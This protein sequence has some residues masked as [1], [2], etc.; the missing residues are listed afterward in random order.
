MDPLK[1]EERGLADYYETLGVAKGASGDEIKKAYRKLAL[2][3]HPD[4]NKQ[5]PNAEEKFK[6]ISEAYAVLSDP[7][8]KKQYDAFGDQGFHQRYSS[9]DIFRGADSIFQEFDLG[10]DSFF[11]KIFGNQFHGG[12][13]R[14][15]FRPDAQ[16][17]GQ[18]VEYPL[19]V[20]F[21]EAYRGSERR[22]NFRL[23]DGSSRDLKVRIPAG[24]ETGKKLRVSGAGA[25]SPYGGSPG[26]L[27]IVLTVSSHP[28]FT[29][30]GM[31]IETPLSLKISE[32]LLGTSAEVETPEGMKRIRVPAGVKPGTKIRLKDLGFPDPGKKGIRGNLFAVIEFDVPKELDE[33]QRQVVQEMQLAGL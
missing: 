9:E 14:G 5:N 27:Y 22:I 33:K 2:E 30:K 26:D 29:R 18:D 13:G 8:K 25:P 12:G 1:P 20:G 23:N 21:D 15:G 19:T 17:Q 31:D 28:T 11:S 32:G 10:G 4:R 24:I 6:Q 3:Y 16:T 7:Q